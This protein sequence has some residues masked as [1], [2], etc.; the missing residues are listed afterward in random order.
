MKRP[1]LS[2]ALIVTVAGVV[3]VGIGT[4]TMRAQQPA[5]PPQPATVTVRTAPAA[6]AVTDEML[7]KPNPA[8]WLMWRRTLDSHGFSPLDQVNRSNVGK[9]KMTWTRGMG[10]GNIQEATPLV[11]NGVMYLPNP[12]DFYQAFDARSGELL[13]EYRRKLPTDLAKFMPAFVMPP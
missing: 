9:L 11:Y 10:P 13:W 3:S 8:D 7:W 12:N 1:T 4:I 6:P 5:A 2:I